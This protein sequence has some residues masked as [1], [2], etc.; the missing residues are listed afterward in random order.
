M[1]GWLMKQQSILNLD[2]Q[3]FVYVGGVKFCRLDATAG[4]L[5]F[6]DKD[7]RRCAGR[8]SQFVRVEVEQFLEEMRGLVG[9]D[10]GEGV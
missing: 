7:R 5:L 2:E 9:G 8:G 1:I 6:L 10:S 3:G 4:V